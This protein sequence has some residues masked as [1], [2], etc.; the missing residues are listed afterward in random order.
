MPIPDDLSEMLTT[1]RAKFKRADVAIKAWMHERTH[2]WTQ[3][4]IIVLTGLEATWAL[5][6]LAYK[7]WAA[8][9]GAFDSWLYDEG[10][11]SS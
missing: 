3:D 10:R 2:E 9:L 7:E 5:Y 8:A 1:A 6:E 4:G 11:W